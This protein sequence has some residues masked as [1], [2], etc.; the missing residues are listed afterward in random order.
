MFTEAAFPVWIHLSRYRI[1]PDLNYFHSSVQG[2]ASIH[3]QYK[4][5]TYKVQISATNKIKYK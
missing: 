1:Y 4:T 3:S 5:V 2:I